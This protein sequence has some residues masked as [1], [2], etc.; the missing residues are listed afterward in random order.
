MVKG[1]K[2]RTKKT[3]KKEVKGKKLEKTMK[4]K[5][6]RN[7][8]R[9]SIIIPLQTTVIVAVFRL[10]PQATLRVVRMNQKTKSKVFA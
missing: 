6:R 5:T 3:I 7:Q 4:S 2:E 1:K 8:R 10:L 9:E